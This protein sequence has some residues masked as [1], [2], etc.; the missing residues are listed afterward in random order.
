M[1][2]GNFDQYSQQG[3]KA[4]SDE[5]LHG[6]SLVANP[7]S[8]DSYPYRPFLISLIIAIAEMTGHPKLDALRKL[9]WTGRLAR[10]DMAGLPFSSAQALM[11]SLE[12]TCVS[13]PENKESWISI[14]CARGI[15]D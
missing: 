13:I 14:L 8:K 12:W 9:D 3:Q 11:G 1:G 5:L 2:S 7:T 15:V 6:E 10:Q 4:S